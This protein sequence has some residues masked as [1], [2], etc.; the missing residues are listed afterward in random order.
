MSL[1]MA[2]GAGPAWRTTTVRHRQA[3]FISD[4][5][6]DFIG[7]QE[8][9]VNLHPHSPDTD[10]A[11]QILPSTGTLI[12]GVAQHVEPVGTY[13]N[14]LWVAP[15]HQVVNWETVIFDDA[16]YEE[17]R[18]LLLVTVLL[19]DGRTIVVGVTH[20]SVYGPRPASLRAKQLAG[21]NARHIDVLLGDFNA[22]E[23][24][25]GPR[26]QT[27]INRTGDIIDVVRSTTAYPAKGRLIPTDG[28][29]DHAFAAFA[30]FP[31]L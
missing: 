16:G 27:L 23:A 29:S 20:L 21:I 6:A 5:A 2:T 4:N 15:A 9:A 31:A 11:A 18:S 26:L 24:E 19:A 13:G 17:P 22:L 30:R 14:A 7:L 1:N 3:R 25:V 12:H 8:V 10:S 28:A